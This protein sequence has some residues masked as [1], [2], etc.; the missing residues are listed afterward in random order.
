MAVGATVGAVDGV[1]VVGN[2]EGIIVGVRD[3][4]ILGDAVGVTV[5]A[6]VDGIAVVGDTEGLA[7]GMIVGATDGGGVG[8]V[9]GASVGL[10]V[11]D[12]AVGEPAAAEG[13]CVGP[14]VGDTLGPAE[15]RSDGDSD[16]VR[17]LLQL[18]MADA[19]TLEPS[20]ASGATYA[21]SPPS[22]HTNVRL[23]MPPKA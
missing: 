19:L 13:S 12:L 15:G 4:D 17:A 14:A 18:T 10:A 7:E 1:V 21:G 23:D 2:T 6:A 16:G 11:D 22:Q 5:G 8:L 9:D 3:G 20:N